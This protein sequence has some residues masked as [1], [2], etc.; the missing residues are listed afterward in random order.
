MFGRFT[1]GARRAVDLAQAEARSMGHAYIGTE[2]LLLGLLGEE[3]GIAARILRAAGITAAA[4]RDDVQRLVTDLPLSG[5]DAEALRVIGIDVDVV[6]AR[7]EASFGP[8]SLERARLGGCARGRPSRGG[9]PLSRRSRKV[10]E[11]SLREALRLGHDYIG[12][13]HILLALL[14]KD[15]GLAAQILAD[16]G[17]PADDLRRSVL[18][19]VGKVA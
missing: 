12:T 5:P 1:S 19:A 8:G 16:S 17:V 7:I 14:G 6:R 4:V 10:M 15:E 3:H 13:E 9:I 11:R 18:A 2:H